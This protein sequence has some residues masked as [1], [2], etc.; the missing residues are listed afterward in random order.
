[1]FTGRTTIMQRCRDGKSR[2]TKARRSRDEVIADFWARVDKRGPDECWEWQGGR[3]GKAAKESYGVF[4]AFGTRLKAHRFAYEITKGEL[5][6]GE[7][8]CHKCD[9]PPCCN[10]AHLFAGT[11]AVNAQD[12]KAKGRM[13]HQCGEAR[14]NATLTDEKVREIRS[15]YQKRKVGGMGIDRLAELYGVGRTMIY[16]IVTRQRWAHVE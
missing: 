16:A 3:N 5:K 7:M 6:H 12:C 11:P 1:M 14:Y 9:N 4:W 10:P 2:P 8:A 15:R 13:N